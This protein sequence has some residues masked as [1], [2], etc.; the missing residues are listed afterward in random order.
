M[1]RALG[2]ASRAGEREFALMLGRSHPARRST[3]N[4]SDF[5]LIRSYPSF[6]LEI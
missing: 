5:D 6:D 1:V 4:G 2:G 3:G